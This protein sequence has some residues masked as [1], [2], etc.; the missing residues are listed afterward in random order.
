MGEA[1][2]CQRGAHELKHLA[3]GSAP[4]FVFSIAKK[5]AGLRHV[6]IHSFIHSC[7]HLLQA[8]PALSKKESTCL[9][10]AS[11]PATEL[12]KRAYNRCDSRPTGL[13]RVPG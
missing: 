5:D 10:G 7:R 1:L 12:T 8:H 3:M 6:E 4:S 13:C 11:S 2:G 9:Y